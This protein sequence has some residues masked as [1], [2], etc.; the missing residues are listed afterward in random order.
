VLAPKDLYWSEWELPDAGEI[1]GVSLH[2]GPVSTIDAPSPV[3]GLAAEGDNVYWT[4]DGRVLRTP[5]DGGAGA[6]LAS[7]QTNP[8]N[9][10]VRQGTLFWADGFSPGDPED[11]QILTSSVDGGVPAVFSGASGQPGWLAINS[12]RQVWTSI[13]TVRD[14]GSNV[15]IALVVTRPLGGGPITTLASSEWPWTAPIAIDEENL[16][17]STA[18]LATSGTA[19]LLRIPLQGGT[20]VTIASGFDLISGIA[21]DDT[22]VYWTDEYRGEVV[23]LTPK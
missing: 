8:G 23:R 5:L 11:G 4:N 6:T 1:H 22:S 7:G 21:V 16:Y 3:Q 17:V 13:S 12:T 20:S 19:V 9:L 14:A 10:V 18:N 15:A 2:G